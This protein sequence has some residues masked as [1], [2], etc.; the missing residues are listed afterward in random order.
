MEVDNAIK[1]LGKVGK[2]Q[3]CL[4]LG[5]VF[6]LQPP[7]AWNVLIFTFLGKHLKMFQLVQVSVSTSQKNSTSKAYEPPHHCKL[8]A[9]STVDEWIPH[10][11]SGELS[12]CSM[13]INSSVCN[14]TSACVHGWQFDQSLSGPTMVS[15][16]LSVAYTCV[17]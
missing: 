10:D 15:K 1:K 14:Q 13:F 5:V 11:S 3:L 8:P 4:Q 16:V 7:I 6:L 2:W 9:N 12:S 17:F